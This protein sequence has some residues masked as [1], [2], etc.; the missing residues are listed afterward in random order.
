MITHPSTPLTKPGRQ[1]LTLTAGFYIT[2]AF[3]NFPPSS[4]LPLPSVSIT[5][6]THSLIH[7]SPL[8][9]ASQIMATGKLASSESS[10]SDI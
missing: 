2:Q 9:P 7:S 6:T 3:L 10:P 8:F 4:H 5:S 1:A